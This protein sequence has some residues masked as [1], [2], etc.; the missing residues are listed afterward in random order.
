MSKDKKPDMYD[1][2][3]DDSLWGNQE[4]DSLSHDDIMNKD[5]NKVTGQKERWKN[6]DALRK[7]YSKK[8][9]KMNAKRRENPELMAEISAKISASREGKP[10]SPRAIEKM[11]NTKREKGILHA[12]SWNKGIS[13]S[14]KTREKLAKANTGKTLDEKTK[15]KIAKNC[16]KNKSIQTPEGQF[17]SMSAAGRHYWDNKLTPRKSLASARMWIRDQVMSDNPDF[18]FVD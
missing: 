14:E 13:P 6:N 1:F 4:T 7:E 2:F 18:Y 15:E 5:W 9:K 3:N 10:M 17:V 16:A 11:L 8:A 12:P